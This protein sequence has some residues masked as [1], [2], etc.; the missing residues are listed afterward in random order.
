MVDVEQLL[1]DILRREGGFV[2]HPDDRGGPTKF[3]ITLQVL[4]S[5]LGRAVTRNDVRELSEDLAREIYKRNYFYGAKID[6]LPEAIQAFVFDS[7]VNHGQGRAIK[8]VQ[9]VCNDAGYAKR[10][11]VDGLMGPNTCRAA[12]WAQETMAAGFLQALVEKRRNFYYL[13]AELRPSQQVFLKGWL[14]RI[15]EFDQGVA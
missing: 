13:I 12:E 7:A 10:L 6:T 1:D 14:N 8:F 15:D 5:Y 3:G 4:A 11:R 2:D 9:E